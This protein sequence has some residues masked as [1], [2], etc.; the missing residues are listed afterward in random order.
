MQSVHSDISSEVSEG[1]LAVDCGNTRLKATWM[2]EAGEYVTA[3]FASDDAEGIVAF[4][5]AHDARRGAM[6]SV[7]HV[8]SRLVE[9]LRNALHEDFLLV[10]PSTVMPVAL[11]YADATTLGVDRKA[12][13]V[14]AAMLWPGESVIVADA[15]TALTVDVVSDGRFAGGN[16]SPGLSMRFEALHRYTARL[17]LVRASEWHGQLPLFG[18]STHDAIL[19]GVCQGM[20]GELQRY[21]SMGARQYGATRLVLTGGDA[22]MLLHWWRESLHSE[23]SSTPS[24]NIEI[25]YDPHLLAKGLRAIYM[26]HENEI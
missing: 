1:F 6:A 26:H 2:P 16:I 21:V 12:T 23:D 11:D 14:A 4:A 7:G 10:T 3:W 15:G 13:A 18:G 20:L 24:N 8:D 25:D 5:E 9:T 22:P 19:A 17:P